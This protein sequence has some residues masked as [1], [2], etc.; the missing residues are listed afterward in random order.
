MIDFDFAPS[1]GGDSKPARKPFTP[2]TLTG[3]PRAAAQVDARRSLDKIPDFVNS[4]CQ[5]SRPSARR[6]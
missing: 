2:F 3:R 6:C 5:R 1:S 4:A